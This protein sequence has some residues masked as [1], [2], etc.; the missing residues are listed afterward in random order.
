MWSH[1]IVVAPLLYK[2]D[3][4]KDGQLQREKGD[5]TFFLQSRSSDYKLE[6]TEVPRFTAPV[7]GF[8]LSGRSSASNNNPVA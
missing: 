8:N 7:S 5:R 3:L 1:L 4:C 6:I 2:A